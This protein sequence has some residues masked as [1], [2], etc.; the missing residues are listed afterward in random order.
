M[1]SYTIRPDFSP[2]ILS[3][4]LRD[5]AF[6]RS[7]FYAF[8]GKCNSWTDDNSPPDLTISCQSDVQIRDNIVYI[9]QISANDVSVVVPRYD[10]TTGITW[11]QYDH[12]Q[13]MI[14][15]NFYCITDDNNVYKCLNNNNSVPSTVKPTTNSIY[16]IQTSDGYIWKYMYNIPDIKMT[17]FATD[18]FIPTQKALQDTFYNNGSI[19]GVTIVNG[20]SG[21]T[22]TSDVGITVSGGTPT[23]PAILVPVVDSLGQIIKVVIVDGGTGYSAAPT[24][25]VTQTGTTGTGQYGTNTTAK[26]KAFIDD[27]VVVNVTIEDPGIDYQQTNPTT[28][29]VSGDGTGAVFIPLVYGGTIIDVVMEN[30]GTAYTYAKLTVSG[31]GINANIT[32]TIALSDI[33]SDQSVVEQTTVIGAIY[34]IKVTNGGN[35]YSSNTTT[36][37]ITGDGTGATCVPVIVGG[38]IQKIQMTAFGSGYTYANVTITDSSRIEQ[39]GYVTATAYAILPPCYGHGFDAV[40]EFYSSAICLYTTF[41]DITELDQLNQDYR[42]YGLIKDL[43]DIQTNKIVN[44]QSGLLVSVIAIADTTNIDID[45]VITSNGHRYL[46]LQKTATTL[47]LQQIDS[48]YALPSS[49]I[50]DA[51]SNTQNIIDLV[52]YNTINKH[53]GE[54]LYTSNT[55]PFVVNSNEYIATLKTIITL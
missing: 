17:K 28:I 7:H 5:I 1:P 50:I 31:T 15:T 22:T 53:S 36:V 55:T 12:T 46:V 35:F 4:T 40:R 37:T 30:T 39:P 24:L 11:T 41:H 19:S 44:I 23:T 33:I 2:S 20:G 18:A 29:T 8:L 45:D 14:D 13:T 27:G 54:L 34:A 47:T 3:S 48:K 38:A 42:Q 32:A 49:S 9:K 52:S 21:Y 51:N 6:K 16:P 25:T 10:W 26:C 43:T